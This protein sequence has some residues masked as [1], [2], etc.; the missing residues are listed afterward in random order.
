[1]PALFRAILLPLAGCVA[2]SAPAGSASGAD[3]VTI[4]AHR[5][6]GHPMRYHL[7][8]P[9]GWTADHRWPV[10]V[11]I[12]DANRDFEANLARFVRARGDRPYILVAPEVLSCGGGKSRTPERY[13]YPRAV[14]DSLQ[15]GDDFAFEDAGLAAVLADVQR[16]W[17]GE[18]TAFLTG[19]EAGGHT[20]W[21]Q[22][23]R[24]PERWRGVAPV[25]PNYQRRG[26]DSTTVSRAPERTG[27]PI[28]V[29]YCGAPTGEMARSM[30]FLEQQTALALRDARD[31]GFDPRPVRV[32]PGA[33]HGPLPE[34]V[35]AWCDSLRRN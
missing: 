3:P 1:M 34:A 21:A 26:V 25:T 8:L 15:G 16:Q 9:S 20:V 2:L 22:A 4:S 29:L 32:V 24:H 30:T 28:Q 12:P 18:P 17:R 31:H 13:S 33:D 14:W 23:L 10:L 7:A 27:L 11:A 6:S 5:A 19:W 35:L